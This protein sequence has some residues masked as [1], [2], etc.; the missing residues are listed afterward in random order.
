MN[1]LYDQALI[2]SSILYQDAS[3]TVTLLDL[4]HSISRAS[5]LH[6]VA[7]A[8]P[9]QPFPSTEPKG[10]KR[11]K[12]LSSIPQDEQDYHDQLAELIADTM[13]EARQY[14]GQKKW[15]LDRA[16][17]VSPHGNHSTQGRSDAPKKESNRA[18]YSLKRYRSGSSANQHRLQPNA[19]EGALELEGLEPPTHITPPLVLSSLG[20]EYDSVGALQNTVIFNPFT[21]VVRIH[22]PER[23]FIVPPRCAF[24]SSSIQQGSHIFETSSKALGCPSTMHAGLFDFILLDPPWPNR[25]VRN[26]K[27]YDTSERQ[28]E[29]HPF[30]QTLPII[31][32]HLSPAGITAVWITNKRAIRQAVL[33]SL[34]EMGLGLY[35]EWIWLKVTS[36]GEPVTTLDGLWR[37]P[38][39]V[40]LLF[41]RQVAMHGGQGYLSEYPEVKKRVV[42]AVPDIHS[43][44][45]CLKELLKP[46]LVPEDYT[47]L[48]IFARNLTAGLWSWGNEVLKFNEEGAA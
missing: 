32:R 42:I 25:S 23:S 44:K 37:K 35:E 39:E 31:D 26:A 13:L 6:V 2:M 11:A 14:M 41:C 34:H 3:R 47:A 43:R 29:E 21:S 22:V 19:A 9:A 1:F 18:A 46:P 24:L 4:P 28:L 45:P 10:S 8:G 20:S 48:E 16:E 12:M 36:Y 38:Y 30:Y 17:A 27:V 40:L 15:C 5:G 33:R 7:S